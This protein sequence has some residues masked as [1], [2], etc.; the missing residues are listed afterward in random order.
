MLDPARLRKNLPMFLLATAADGP[1]MIEKN[2]AR[3]SGSLIQCKYVCQA[4][5]GDVWCEAANIDQWI[6]HGN[7]GWGNMA[8]PA[9]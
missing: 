5:S 6:E 1:G 3:A 7:R 9:R 4:A 2:R 8:W